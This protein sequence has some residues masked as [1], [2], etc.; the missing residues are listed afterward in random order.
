MRGFIV[1]AA[2]LVSALPLPAEQAPDWAVAVFPSGAEF[3]LEVANTP[4]KRQI[5]YMFREEIPSTEGML[6]LFGATERHG[7]WMRNCLA[8]LDIIW[9]DAAFRVL[10]IFPDAQPCRSDGPCPSMQP[11]QAAD[12]VLEIAG[13]RAAEE[14]LRPGDLIIIHAEPALR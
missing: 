6:F 3:S 12:Y 13:G 10:E 14:E 4:R 2:L 11:M 5:G 8:P 1:C 7:I 9:L